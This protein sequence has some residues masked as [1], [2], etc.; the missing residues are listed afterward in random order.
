MSRPNDLILITIFFL[1]LSTVGFSQ[2]E[3]INDV[4]NVYIDCWWCDIDY[5]KTEISYVQYVRDRQEADVHI[6]TTQQRTGGGGQEYTLTFIGQ[7]NFLGVN[8]TLVFV[9]DP[10]DTQDTFRQE[11]VRILKLGLMPYLTKTSVAKNLS[12]S[13]IEPEEVDIKEVEDKWKNW[14]FRTRLNTSL[15]GET[16]RNSTSL[17]GSFSA[18]KVT[19]EWKIGISV[20]GSYNEDNIDWDGINI[21]SIRRSQYFKSSAIKSLTDHWSIGMW[22]NVGSSTYNN[23]DYHMKVEPGIEYNY[24]PYSESTRRQLRFAYKVGPQYAD[25]ME[26]TIYFKL[27]EGLF[28]ESL[29]IDWDI[30]QPWGSISTSL[31]GTHFFHDFNKNSLNLYTNFSLKLIKGLSFSLYLSGSRIHNQLS[32]PSEGATLEEVLLQRKQLETQYYYYSSIGLTYSFGSIYS[33]VVNPR[34]G[35][36]GRMIIFF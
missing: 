25:Y 21:T 3:S 35:G 5:I 29:S 23:M 10:T 22:A 33:H 17:S 19:E 1:I 34:F 20:S 8:D 11:M 4:P 27:N 16:T 18:N 31:S 6:L 24:F 15:S 12:I 32:I 28:E 9:T 30:I 36:S 13:F 26:E 2:T 14:V 7:N